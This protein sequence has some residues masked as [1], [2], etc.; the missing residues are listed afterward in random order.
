MTLLD[1]Q[2][3]RSLDH[4]AFV[5]DTDDAYVSTLVPLM[6]RAIAAGDTV[7]S[8][9]PAHNAAL[10]RHAL[11]ADADEVGFVAAD[12]WYDH[13]VTTIARYDEVLR[14]Q[15]AGVSAFVV[16]EVQF[17]DHQSDWTAWTRY[18]AALNEVLKHHDARVI[19]PYDARS[20][21]APV[22]DHARC[23]H[24]HLVTATGAE[25]SAE[26]LAPEELFAL[27]PPTVEIPSDPP[28]LDLAVDTNLRAARRAFVDVANAC[29][30]APLVVADL[31]LA[32]SEVLS[33]AIEHG[34]GA[35]RLRVWTAD[36]GLTCVVDDT[37]PG[38]DDPL[39]GYSGPPAG[40]A[41]GYGTWIARRH[42]RH[43]EFLR[44]PAGGLSVMLSTQH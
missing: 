16:G 44:S 18:E 37:G 35:A 36:G 41:S 42:F 28:A 19:C 40:S 1:H 24:P 32:L 6:R 4:D 14:R 11:G 7:M 43:S 34:G 3:S 13:P 27:L 33:N 23:T 8:V 12:Q 39:L 20:L 5:Y 30:I 21:P 25:A 26:Y 31:T 22:L 10:L 38:I 15:P 29:G 2:R 9:V 17:G